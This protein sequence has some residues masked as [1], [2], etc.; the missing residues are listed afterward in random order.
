MISYHKYRIAAPL[1]G[2]QNSVGS[3][4]FLKLNRFRKDK[5]TTIVL[6]LLFQFTKEFL[7]DT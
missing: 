4:A 6:L 3:F 7:L 2:T 1:S 5:S